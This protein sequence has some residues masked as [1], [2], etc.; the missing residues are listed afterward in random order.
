[1]L[2]AGAGGATPT[3]IVDQRPYQVRAGQPVQVDDLGFQLVGGV[4]CYVAEPN[5]LGAASVTI[6]HG[7]PATAIVLVPNRTG[8]IT[9][10]NVFNPPEPPILPVTGTDVTPWAL[11]AS[12]L[13]TLGA[14]VPVSRRLRSSRRR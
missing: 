7:T 9:T 6:D 2:P 3:T 4:E 12:A 10:T 14:L 13:L 5:G 1:M 8:S 11:L